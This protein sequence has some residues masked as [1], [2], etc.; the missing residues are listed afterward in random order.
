MRKNTNRIKYQKINKIIV[1]FLDFVTVRHR[2]SGSWNKHVSIH[3]SC[4]DFYRKQLNL[5]LIATVVLWTIIIKKSWEVFFI[6]KCGC[7]SLENPRSMAFHKIHFR[8]KIKLIWKMSMNNFLGKFIRKLNCSCC[9]NWESKRKMK[10]N[11]LR[12]EKIY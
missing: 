5:C 1:I 2:F 12:S 4:S 8:R 3:L 10:N 11:F 7:F 9:W 6:W